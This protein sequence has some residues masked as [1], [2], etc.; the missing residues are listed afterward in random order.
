MPVFSNVGFHSILF[1]VFIYW[2]RKN[3]YFCIVED[4][5]FLNCGG[6]DLCFIFYI[7]L[8]FKQVPVPFWVTLIAC[9]FLQTTHLP[10][11][12]Y[13]YLQYL[14]VGS[15]VI[16]VVFLCTFPCI[17]YYLI[18][19]LRKDV[20]YHRCI[21]LIQGGTSLVCLGCLYV[22]RYGCYM[23]VPWLNGYLLAHHS[24]RLTW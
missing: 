3:W 17:S 10:H 14:E 15:F 8:F 24:Y 12:V 1:R 23:L 18:F 5:E 4:V 9:R 19:S 7:L 13:F 20:L 2:G 11:P 22:W 16:L 21:E 6:N